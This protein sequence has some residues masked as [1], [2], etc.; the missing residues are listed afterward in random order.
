MDIYGY[1]MECYTA[2]KKN[3][4]SPFA[5][6]WMELVQRI[7]VVIRGEASGEMGKIGKED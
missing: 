1:V 6:T 4:I 5:K 2:I 3:E 7:Q